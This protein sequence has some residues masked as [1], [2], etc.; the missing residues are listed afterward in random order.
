MAIPRRVLAGVAAATLLLSAC[1]ELEE[2]TTD[3]PTEGPSSGTA[4]PTPS[5]L[6]QDDATSTVGD[7]DMQTATSM[8]GDLDPQTSTQPAPPPDTDTSTST[9]TGSPT[10]A[11]TEAP[12]D[13]ALPA[14]S[15]EAVQQSGGDDAALLPTT[16]RL[17]LHDGYDRVVFDLEGETMP[18]YRVGYVD[19]AVQD[20][21]GRII[22]VAGDAILQVVISGTRYPEED[23]SYQGGPGTYTLDSAEVV[24]QVRASGT[25]EGLTQAFIGIDDEGSPFRVFTLSGPPRLVVDIQ[26]P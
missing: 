10:A 5:T 18:G 4:A 14:F 24:E 25:F 7:Q 16:V 2:A 12:A 22:D 13:E 20:G 15:A 21:S 11:P 19:Q 26:H 6:D 3:P 1:S 9:A 8:G 17:G 23:E